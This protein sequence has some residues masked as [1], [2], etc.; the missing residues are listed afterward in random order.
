MFL[1]FKSAKK[2]RKGAKAAKLVIDQLQVPFPLSSSICL[3]QQIVHK[4]S[5]LFGAK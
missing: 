2:G 1:T 4:K 3:H 5:S